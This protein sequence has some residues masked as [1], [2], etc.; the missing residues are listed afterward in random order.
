M[1]S[2]PVLAELADFLVDRGEVALPDVDGVSLKVRIRIRVFSQV[3][4][5][6]LAALL[7]VAGPAGGH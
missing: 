7:Y 6:S 5:Q 4:R 1:A 2:D 3:I